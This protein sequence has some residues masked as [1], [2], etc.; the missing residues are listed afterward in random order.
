MRLRCKPKA[1]PHYFGRGIH[2]LD[3][4]DYAQNEGTV[5][6]IYIYKISFCLYPSTQNKLLH[7]TQVSSHSDYSDV[8]IKRAGCI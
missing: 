7:H 1:L 3:V 6:V 5:Q 2:A 8:P 4:L